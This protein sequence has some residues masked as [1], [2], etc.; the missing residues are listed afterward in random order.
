M[1]TKLKLLDETYK[2]VENLSTIDHPHPEL[3]E[4]YDGDIKVIQ[5]QVKANPKKVWTVLDH[6]EEIDGYEHLYVIAGWH[7]VNRLN[8]I[9]TEQEWKS[10][11][12]QYLY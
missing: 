6:G 8:Y 3:I 12:E 2:I 11:D 7:F 5:D 9:I 1:A 4:T 10:E